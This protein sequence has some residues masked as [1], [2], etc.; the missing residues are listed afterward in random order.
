MRTLFITRWRP[1]R[2]DGGAPL[3]K[4]QSIAALSALG[5]V[6]VLSIGENEVVESVPGIGSWHHFP[7]RTHRYSVRAAWLLSPRYLP[8]LAPYYHPDAEAHLASVLAAGTY[9]LVV[10]EE[11]Y[12]ARYV[13][14]VRAAGVPVVL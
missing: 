5:A 2:P 4:A 10:V 12:L 11:I 6:D 3:R 8:K 14:T 9:D 1:H 7:W 13:P